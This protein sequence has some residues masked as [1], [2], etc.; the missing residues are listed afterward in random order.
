MHKCLVYPHNNIVKTLQ[1]Q[2]FSAKIFS[3]AVKSRIIKGT[4]QL[5]IDDRHVVTPSM[6]Y[7]EKEGNL[8][9]TEQ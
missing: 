2:L 8:N 4:H 3:I 7:E 9:V 1:F 5:S 6:A